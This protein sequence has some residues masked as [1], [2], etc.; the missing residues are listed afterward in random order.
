MRKALLLML[1]MLMIMNFSA[2]SIP[3]LAAPD[4]PQPPQGYPRRALEMVV[5]F[6]PAGPSDIAARVIAEIMKEYIGVP[7]NVVNRPGGGTVTGLMHAYAQPADGYTMYFSTP[8]TVI[9]EAQNLAPVSFYE[10]FVPIG[11]VQIDVVVFSVHKDNKK[12]QTLEELIDYAKKHPG[13]V[14]VGG[15]SPR[16]LDD[17]LTNGFARAAGIE[18]TFVPYDS[19]GEQK[20]AFLGREIDVYQDKVPSLMTMVDLKEVVPFVVLYNRRLHDVSELVNVPCTV[21]KGIDF[22]QGSWRGLGFKKGTPQE[23]VDYM[24]QIL[25]KVYLSD[26]YQARAAVDNS[27][28][29][30]GYLTAKETGKKWLEE[31]VM[32]KDIFDKYFR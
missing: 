1:V 28:I 32:F 25:H 14:T 3:A 24:E 23:I 17:Y 2:V 9:I 18:L 21:E 15:Q 29:I 12:F 4:M 7:V 27:N 10:N 30:P 6:G 19:A 26:A 31:V 20:T 5:P 13:E 8:S 16:G 11:N 22:T